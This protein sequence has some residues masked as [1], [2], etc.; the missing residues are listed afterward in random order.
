MWIWAA[1]CGDTV[2]ELAQRK[3]AARLNRCDIALQ[4]ATRRAVKLP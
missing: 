1:I 2:S 4:F 3:G